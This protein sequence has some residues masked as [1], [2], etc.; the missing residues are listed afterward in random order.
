MYGK[1]LN[2]QKGLLDKVCNDV[3]ISEDIIKLVKNDLEALTE[4][5]KMTKEEAQEFNKTS[6]RQR[7]AQR[8]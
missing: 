7:K 6:A 8:G 1:I 2:S 5:S 4:L 3:K